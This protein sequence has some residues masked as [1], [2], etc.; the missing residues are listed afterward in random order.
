GRS[1][2]IVAA[3]SRLVPGR[4]AVPIAALRLLVLLVAL[5]VTVTLM[6]AWSAAILLRAV[7]LRG[8]CRARGAPIGDRNGQ[9]DQLFDSA[10]ESHLFVVAERDRDAFGAGPRGAADAMHVAFRDVRQVVIDDVADA[11]D[12]DAARRD[13]GRDQRTHAPRTKSREHALAL[14]LRLVA[15]D[16]LGRKSRVVQAAHHLV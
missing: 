1:M 11:V 2:A 13:V 16:R 6:L 5:R 7:M 9:S 4:L 14:V 12:V 10:Q 3:A 8:R 15:V